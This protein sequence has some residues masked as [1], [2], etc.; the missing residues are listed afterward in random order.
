MAPILPELRSELRDQQPSSNLRAAATALLRVTPKLLLSL[1]RVWRSV[2]WL[3]VIRVTGGEQGCS[4][5]SDDAKELQW[6]Y[7]MVSISIHHYVL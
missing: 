5:V 6:G 1:L 2:P 3:G 7:S 4:G